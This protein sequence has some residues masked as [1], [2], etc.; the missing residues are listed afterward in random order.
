VIPISRLHRTILRLLDISSG[1]DA[2]LVIST[3]VNFELKINN[4][5]RLFKPF[6]AAD[7]TTF[8]V[9]SSGYLTLFFL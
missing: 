7:V 9:N 6:N 4:V 8:L 3:T 2:L 5:Y 1:R